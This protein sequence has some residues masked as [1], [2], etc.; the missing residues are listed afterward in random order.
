MTTI[1]L[2]IGRFFFLYG[3]GATCKTFWWKILSTAIR[4]KGMIVLNIVSS[5]IASLLLFGGKNVHSTFSIPLT[6]IDE[7]TCNINQGSLRTKLLIETK[8]IIWDKA[9]MMNK[10]CFEVFDKTLRDIICSNSE[11]NV[12]RPFGGKFVVLASDFRQSLPI[13]GY[14]GVINKLL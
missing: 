4:S 1:H 2:D 8:L 7:S 9:P 6:I 14:C 10:L 12:E 11:D 3:Y 13:K 5:D